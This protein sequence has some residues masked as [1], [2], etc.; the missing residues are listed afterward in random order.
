[1]KPR[2]K[3]TTTL[4]YINCNAVVYSERSKET[5]SKT[6]VIS[7]IVAIETTQALDRA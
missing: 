6:H 5:D 3:A 7:Q 2:T 4:E 1:M